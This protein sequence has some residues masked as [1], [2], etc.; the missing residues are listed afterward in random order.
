MC[1]E[2]ERE[3]VCAREREND[4]GLYDR[5]LE[6]MTSRCVCVRERERESA[7]ERIFV[8]VCV[9]VCVRVREKA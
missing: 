7:C 2:C 4:E 3:C 9:C 1:A 6:V 5:L 8:C